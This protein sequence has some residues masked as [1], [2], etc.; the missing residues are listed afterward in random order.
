[1]PLTD[2]LTLTEGKSFKTLGFPWIS[3]LFKIGFTKNK[4]KNKGTN[5][6][7]H[8]WHES[9]PAQ[10]SSYS[11]LTPPITNF[12]SWLRDEEKANQQYSLAVHAFQSTRNCRL[13]VIAFSFFFKQKCGVIFEI[14][15]SPQISYIFNIYRHRLIISCC[16]FLDSF[17]CDL[18]EG[19]WSMGGLLNPSSMAVN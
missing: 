12:F 5:L 7:S 16:S 3:F 8:L 4:N 13:S 1:M 19:S 9:K 15:E 11:Q 10:S 6:D 2:C 18:P 17:S 14:L